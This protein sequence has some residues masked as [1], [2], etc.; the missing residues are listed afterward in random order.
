MCN[1]TWRRVCATIVIAEKQQLLHIQSVLLRF[2]KMVQTKAAEKIKTHVLFYSF[3]RAVY[4]SIEQKYKP[5]SRP[6]E[7]FIKQTY[8]CGGNMFRLLSASH[9]Q[10]LHILLTR[11]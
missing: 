8:I 3:R 1:G 11:I 5:N 10:A 7:L 4:N 2:K 9:H 6:T